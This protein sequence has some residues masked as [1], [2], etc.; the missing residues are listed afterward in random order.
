MRTSEIVNRKSET[1]KPSR[2]PLKNKQ[3][4]K[5]Q[6]TPSSAILKNPWS[7]IMR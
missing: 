3:Y 4:V 7:E 6:M 5:N 1:A 2:T